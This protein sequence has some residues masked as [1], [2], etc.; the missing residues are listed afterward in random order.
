MFDYIK[1]ELINK[2]QNNKGFYFTVENNGIGYFIEVIGKDFGSKLEKEVKIYTVLN[3]K[4]DSMSLCGFL[5]KETRDIFKILT[6]VS[7]IGLKMAL[8]LLNEF[9]TEDLITFVITGDYKSLTNAKGVGTKLAQKIILELKDKLINLQPQT[10]IKESNSLPNKFD[11]VQKVLISLGY[12]CDEINLAIK[13]AMNKITAES[14]TEEVLKIL[15]QNL[16]Q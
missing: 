15:L 8:T 11:D 6:S 7:G 3:H 1:G 12:E 14:S 9:E 5:H 4:E 13:K 10:S 16:S 2:T